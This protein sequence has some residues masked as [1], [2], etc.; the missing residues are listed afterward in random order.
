MTSKSNR[1]LN[2]SF[3]TSYLGLITDLKVSN[4]TIKNLYNRLISYKNIHERFSLIT[5]NGQTVQSVK[6]TLI[7]VTVCSVSNSYR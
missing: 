6:R 7:S 2:I 5:G 3:E 1:R 4:V